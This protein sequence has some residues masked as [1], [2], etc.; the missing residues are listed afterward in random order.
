[1]VI[2]VI[3]D[4]LHLVDDIIPA[5]DYSSLVNLISFDI[6]PLSG[7]SLSGDLTQGKQYLGFICRVDLLVCSVSHPQRPQKGL[8]ILLLPIKGQD[9]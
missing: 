2:W 1:M 3:E 9:G 6:A 4:L 7:K 8:E 5:T